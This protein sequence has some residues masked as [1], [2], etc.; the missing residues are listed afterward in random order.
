M[1]T[2][3]SIKMRAVDAAS[4]SCLCDDTTLTVHSTNIDIE[5]K[6]RTHE[7]RSKA[8]RVRRCRLSQRITTDRDGQS[9]RFADNFL[10]LV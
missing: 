9:L 3:K 7:E 5:E 2:K 10:L 4:R 8:L 1:T 6:L